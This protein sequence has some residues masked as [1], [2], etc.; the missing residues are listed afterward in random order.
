MKRY[1]N[2]KFYGDHLDEKNVKRVFQEHYD[3]VRSL[4]PKDR[5]LEYRIEEGWEPLCEFLGEEVPD[6]DFPKGNSTED[7]RTAVRL[8]WKLQSAI[9]L[10]QGLLFVSGV[11]FLSR[12]AVRA[13]FTWAWLKNALRY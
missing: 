2:H 10:T 7:F 9:N 1:L 4:V 11:W 5:L 13:G 6:V 12:Y 3:E 8:I